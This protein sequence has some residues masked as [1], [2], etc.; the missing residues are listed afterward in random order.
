[1]VQVQVD[2]DKEEDRIV[3]IVKA[4]FDLQDKPITVK[5]IIKEYGKKIDKMK[6]EL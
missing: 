1:M 5:R 3:K 4:L 2:L 6:I